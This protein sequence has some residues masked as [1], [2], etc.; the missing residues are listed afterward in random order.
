M[1]SHGPGGGALMQFADSYDRM[2]VNDETVLY[3]TND[4]SSMA[5]QSFE[6]NSDLH[7]A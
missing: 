5:R 3:E 6:Q 2:E 4:S 1:M 7:T